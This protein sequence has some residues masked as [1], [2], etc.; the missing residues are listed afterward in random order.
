MGPRAIEPQRPQ[1]T[2]RT[3]N[4]VLGALRD[5]CGSSSSNVP[6]EKFG[7]LIVY[8]TSKSFVPADFESRNTS[9]LYLPLGR[10]VGLEMWNSVYASPLG[11]MGWLDDD[12]TGAS[13]N[14]Q[15]D[16]TFAA[17]ALPVVWTDA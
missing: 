3:D 8:F 14:L 4:S 9:T 7:A 6:I 13:A 11:A 17:K 2:R 1:R 10:P 16:S 5:L 15:Q 12:T